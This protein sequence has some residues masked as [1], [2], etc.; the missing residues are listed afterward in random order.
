M[1]PA[2]CGPGNSGPG[3]AAIGRRRA[4]AAHWE[5]M[6]RRC[7]PP[8]AGRQRRATQCIGIPCAKFTCRNAS[9]D[10]RGA[11]IPIA[12]ARARGG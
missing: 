10:G 7:D 12:R 5:V 6:R 4:N 9:A 3:V 8:R 1:A 2:F 11:K